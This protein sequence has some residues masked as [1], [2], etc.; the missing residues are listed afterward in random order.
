[1]RFPWHGRADDAARQLAEIERQRER[2]QRQWPAVH[3]AVRPLRRERQLNGWTDTI[4]S[5]FADPPRKDHS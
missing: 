4:V 5:I 3:A 2:V 1:M